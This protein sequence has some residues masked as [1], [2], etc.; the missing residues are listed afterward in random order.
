MRRALPI[1]LGCAIVAALV[2]VLALHTTAGARA[3]AAVLD[4]FARLRSDNV[5]A[6]AADLVRFLDP[7]PYLLLAAALA[8]I[9]LARGLP[10]HAVVVAAVLGGAALTSQLLKPLLAGPRPWETPSASLI[11]D[12]S[13]PSGHTTAAVALALCVVLV[14]PSRPVRA[15]AAGFALAVPC[16]LVLLGTHW[17]SDAVGGFCVAGAWF[18]LGVAALPHVRV[19]AVSRRT[20]AWIVLAGAALVLVAAATRPGSTAA[21]VQDHTTVAAA[22]V[23]LAAACAVLVAGAPLARR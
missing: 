21:F 18:V 20:L 2:Y 11:G 3:D 6:L 22:A 4:A 9:A 17:P 5:D 12:G 23:A 13:W 15:A 10:R 8:A 19:P 7:A 14:L 16:C 1:A